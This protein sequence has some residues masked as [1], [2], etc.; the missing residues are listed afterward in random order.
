MKNLHNIIHKKF[1]FTVELLTLWLPYML[2]SIGVR[3]SYI[4]LTIC[5]SMSV[6]LRRSDFFGY[7][8]ALFFI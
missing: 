7:G 2:L 5:A 8:F 4:I 1:D 3:L 6:C